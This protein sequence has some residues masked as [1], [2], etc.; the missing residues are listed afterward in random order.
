MRILCVIDNLGAGGAQRQL[1][2]L[3]CGFKSHGHVVEF[4]VYYP[5]DH[6]RPQ[7]DKE[8]IP[9]HLGRKP[10]RF[11]LKPIVDLRRCIRSGKYERVIAFLETPAVYAQLAGLGIS[12][13][14]LLISE[15]SIC[16]CP[17]PSIARR[18]KSH[19]HRLAQ[20]TVCNSHTQ[21]NWL[22]DH[23]PFLLP[24]LHVIWNGIDLNKF[25][26]SK[27]TFQRN[28]SRLTLVGIGRI[29]PAKNLTG[30]VEALNLCLARG[31]NVSL[32][33]VG[34]ADD[35][36][37]LKR[38]CD[39]INSTAAKSAWRWLG[40][41]REIPALMLQYDALIIPSLWE[42]MPNVLGEALASGL[43]VLAS[44]VS[45]NPMLVQDGVTGIL[46]KPNQPKDI[47]HAIHRFSELDASN[48]VNMVVAGRAFAERE[49]ALDKCVMKYESLLDSHP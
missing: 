13:V 47:M 1:V 43:P 49:L 39:Q 24:K 44:N 32:H 38:V 12:N 41:S 7:L 25:S 8:N 20:W 3:A 5:H 29:S 31:M 21:R 15:R 16:T 34:R 22:A 26:F 23:F 35:K 9:V 48:R 19:L 6:F 17:K 36:G 10:S 30:L 14:K 4:Y 42:G 40:E 11:S 33:W 27:N 18:F 2:N 37:Y 45:D 46:F 28:G